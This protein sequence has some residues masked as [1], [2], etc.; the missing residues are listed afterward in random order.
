MNWIDIVVILLTGASFYLGYKEGFIK[1]VFDI[2][3]FFLGIFLAIKFAGAIGGVYQSL[4]G[5]AEGSAGII[6]GV[7]IFIFF[8][9]LTAIIVKATKIHD[10]VDHL[11]NKIVGGFI[12]ATQVIIFLSAIFFFASKLSFPSETTTKGSFL[13]KTVVGV[14]PGIIDLIVP[15]K[16]PGSVK[17]GTH[18]KEPI[19]KK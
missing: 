14:L 19:E 2:V 6:G 5:V 4:L 11:L 12:G 16:T 3:G 10:K 18:T 7:T 8:Q 17:K 13:Y 15:S 1:K 9:I